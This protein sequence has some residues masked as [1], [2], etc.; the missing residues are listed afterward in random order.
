MMAMDP[1]SMMEKCMTMM[2]K[3]GIPEGKVK[4]WK[5]MMQIPLA[6]DTPGVICRMAEALGLSEEQQQQ[7]QTIE[8]EARKK[9]LAVLTEEQRKQLEEIA[10]EPEPMMNM[11]EEMMPKMMETMKE[12][13]GKMGSLSK[14]KDSTTP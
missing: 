9:S 10:A 3:A 8:A 7:L 1:K 5:T 6:L 13:M 11:C 2:G 4:R 14:D 12:Q